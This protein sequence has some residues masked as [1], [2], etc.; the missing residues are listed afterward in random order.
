MVVMPAVH[1]LWVRPLGYV[2]ARDLARKPLKLITFVRREP[3][4][5]TV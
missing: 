1:R 3:P 5:T 2:Y 4:I